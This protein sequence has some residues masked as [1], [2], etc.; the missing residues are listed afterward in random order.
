[1]PRDGSGVYTLPAG[2]PVVTGSVISSSVF[3][4]LTSDIATALTDSATY[5]TL[6]SSTG[7]E[8][9]GTASNVAGGTP[10]TL[11]AR[12]KLDRINFAKDFN[13]TPES[14]TS[15][16]TAALRACASDGRL[17]QL[18][19]GYWQ[20]DDDIPLQTFDQV[21]EGDGMNSA[22]IQQTTR[23]KDVFVRGSLAANR[24]VMKNF[25][26]KTK[27]A[28]GAGTI[29]AT[30]TAY[31]ADNCV[32]ADAAGGVL[33]DARKP[34]VCLVSHTS[35][36]FADD[37]ASGKWARAPSAIYMPYRAA[38]AGIMYV[39]KFDM[40]RFQSLGDGAHLGLEFT[41]Q[42]TGGVSNSVSGHGYWVQGG[43]T[44]LLQNTY[45]GICGPDRAGY[46]SG[47]GGT[48]ISANGINA[49]GSIYWLGGPQ[50]DVWEAQ[51]V[52]AIYFATLVGCNL[53]DYTKF[54]IKGRGQGIATVISG[55]N[56]PS[57][58]TYIARTDVSGTSEVRYFGKPRFDVGGTR[59]A[60]ASEGVTSAYL[61]DHNISALSSK[62]SADDDASL[63]YCQ[64]GVNP[65]QM[66]TNTMLN[67][68]ITLGIAGASVAGANTVTS[69][70]TQKIVGDSVR[71]VGRIALTAKDAAMAGQLRITGVPTAAAVTQP[72][73]GTIGRND[74]ITYGA[75]RTNLSISSVTSQN[76][77]LIAKTGSGIATAFA[78]SADVIA[79]SVFDFDI[80]YR[81][82]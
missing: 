38:E 57:Y 10:S 71:L 68:A 73:V 7:S 76:Y 63:L 62:V 41:T 9:V 36:T 6:A 74:N 81:I 45:A 12:I 75:G 2:Q 77:L 22:I 17:V 48:F 55:G 28:V 24:C 52:S 47:G 26:V 29:W 65:R 13:L 69:Q 16:I 39:S 8:L 21:W 40:M 3:N 58:G 50:N 72:G 32:S 44:T 43:N 82:T 4:T 56:R 18:S 70:V 30:G 35:T 31:V 23:G 59:V 78:D 60:D 80:T 34:Y 27:D 79:G 5:P 14:S 19:G 67:T 33:A 49:G 25:W 53:E 54:G 51:A 42:I 61:A 64:A 66:F 46:R 15:A 20:I 1:M 11:S 37:L